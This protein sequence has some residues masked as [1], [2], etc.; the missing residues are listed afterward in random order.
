MADNVKDAIEKNAKGPRRAKGDVGEVQQHSLKDQVE[1]DLRTT[2]P[3]VAPDSQVA[4]TTTASVIF[5]HDSRLP[6]P[7]AILR[8]PYKGREVVVRVLPRGFEYEG[9]VYRSLSAVARAVTGTHWNGYHFFNLK[10]GKNGV[11]DE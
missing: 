3:K 9:E 2:A 5:D 11:A 6:M 4:I 1:A 7:G 8:R 10:P